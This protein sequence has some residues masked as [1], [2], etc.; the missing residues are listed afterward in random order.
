MPSTGIPLVVRRINTLTIHTPDKSEK[1]EKLF[2]IEQ[3]IMYV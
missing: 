3:I 2:L 1:T